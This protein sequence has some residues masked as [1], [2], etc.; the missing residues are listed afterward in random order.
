M[1]LDSGR[2]ENTKKNVKSGCGATL[3][4]SDRKN[5][6]KLL[7]NAK[8]MTNNK[9]VQVLKGKQGIPRLIPIVSLDES[10][11]DKNSL[12]QTITASCTKNENEAST[13]Y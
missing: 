3:S 11:F 13:V 2:V 5:R 12:V 1:R 8:K 7:Q 6:A 9:R 10:F 4:K